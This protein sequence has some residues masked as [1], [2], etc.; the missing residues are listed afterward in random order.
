MLTWSRL[1]SSQIKRT[2][3]RI[4]RTLNER[5]LGLIKVYE[6]NAEPE[7]VPAEDNVIIFG[8]GPYAAEIEAALTQEK[9]AAAEAKGLEELKKGADGEEQF[10][11]GGEGS[12]GTEG[13][14]VGG[15]KIKEHKSR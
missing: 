5:R 4:K 9:A 10:T 3:A 15:E 11:M 14:G 8:E 13:L 6:E 7:E 2:M 12:A 1:L